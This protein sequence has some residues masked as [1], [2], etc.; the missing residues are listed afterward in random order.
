[1]R[2]IKKFWDGFDAALKFL[3][4]AGMVLLF[5]MMMAVCWEVFS[6]Y[7]LGRGTSWVIELSEY[8]I[9]YM[10]FLGTAWVLQQDGHVEMDIVVNALQARTR[11]IT[12]CS[13]SVICAV[14]C[15]LL[16][17]SG[18]D[19]AVDYLQ[20][21]QHRPTLMAPPDFPL[22]AIMPAGFLLLAIQFLRRARHA[23]LAPDAVDRQDRPRSESAA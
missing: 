13:S 15:L 9:L 1:M 19:V 6:R 22:F 3:A 20:R 5:L 14:V 12:R 2:L 11:R 10:T 21:G 4:N 7:F 17:W 8:A 18:A 23:L 16:T